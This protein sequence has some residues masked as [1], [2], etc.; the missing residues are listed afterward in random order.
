MNRF[1]SI[2]IISIIFYT[3]NYL[4]FD[5]YLHN[6]KLNS[7]Q[8]VEYISRIV[9]NV[10]AVITSI[11]A[12]YCLHFE[13]QVYFQTPMKGTTSIGIFLIQFIIG[14]M[15]YDLSLIFY[16]R[17][18]LLDFG[19]LIHH[20]LTLIIFNLGLISGNINVILILFILTEITTPFV[21]Y[22]WILYNTGRKENVVYLVNGAL[23]AIGFLVVR[24]LYVPIMVFSMLQKHH[25]E[26][27]TL[28]ALERNCYYFALMIINVLNAYW[29]YLIWKGFIKAIVGSFKSKIKSN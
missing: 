24:V 10:N 19:S 29:S 9:S 23:M 18:I 26:F 20:A 7:K 3:C 12:I 28:G 11:L 15:I 8:Q 21:N 16:F 17:S 5:K 25:D 27:Q 22:R 2:E 4:L 14:Y 1:N 13:K 6:D